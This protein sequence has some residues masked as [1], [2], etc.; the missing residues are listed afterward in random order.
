M[1][2]KIYEKMKGTPVLFS[3]SSFLLIHKA[4]LKY[5][6]IKRDHSDNWKF[7]LVDFP[8]NESFFKFQSCLRIQS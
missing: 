3:A 1:N 4:S 6:S 8:D 7:T 5:L 2:L